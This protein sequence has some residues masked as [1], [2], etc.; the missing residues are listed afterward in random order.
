MWK[1]YLSRHRNVPNKNKQ[2]PN[3]KLYHVSTLQTNHVLI[4]DLSFI[5]AFADGICVERFNQILDALFLLAML[6]IHW[7][8]NGSPFY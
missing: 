2:N 4:S 3:R 6:H 8:I 5:Y 1:T 7:N